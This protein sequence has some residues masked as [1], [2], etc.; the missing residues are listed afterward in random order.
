MPTTTRKDYRRN[1]ASSL[2]GP[3]ASRGSLRRKIAAIY[4]RLSHRTDESTSP[5]RQL[6]ACLAKADERGYDVPKEYVFSD[7]DVSAFRTALDDRLELA[8]LRL[9]WCELDAVIFFK[10]DRLIRSTRDFAV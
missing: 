10:L 3:A 6:A 2:F 1:H 7:I 9:L 4:I 5:E 8:R